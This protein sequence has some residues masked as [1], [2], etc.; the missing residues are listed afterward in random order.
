[1]SFSHC[2]IR[3]RTPLGLFQFLYDGFLCLSFW[4]WSCFFSFRHKVHEL[5]DFIQ[6]DDKLREE[7]KKAKKN[8]DK[9][10]GMSSDA[11]GMR[12]GK[13]HCVCT[14]NVLMD[15][16]CIVWYTLICTIHFCLNTVW[17]LYAGCSLDLKMDQ[18][19]EVQ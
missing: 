19:F 13:V 17:V 10:V 11:M 5:I 3:S 6:D 7:R 1:V 8:K 9:Y 16:V 2:R 12:F 4:Q 15:W 18:T 14:R